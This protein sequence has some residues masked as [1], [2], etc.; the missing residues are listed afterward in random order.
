VAFSHGVLTFIILA[1]SG[2]F[3]HQYMDNIVPKS[4]NMKA[5]TVFKLLALSLV[6][7]IG[8]TTATTYDSG[9]AA[10]ISGYK[11]GSSTYANSINPD[12]NVF[13]NISVI[14]PSPVS[15]PYQTDLWQALPKSDTGLPGSDTFCSPCALKNATKTFNSV[16]TDNYKNYKYA[17]FYFGASAGAGASGGSGCCG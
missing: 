12:L 1:K 10:L 13:G 3:K 5:T 6:S 2:N 15:D 7:I 17:S 11:M 9:K 16:L 14:K 8:P 4:D